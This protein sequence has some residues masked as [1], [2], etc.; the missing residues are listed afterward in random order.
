MALVWCAGLGLIM[1]AVPAQ[2]PVQLLCLA[3]CLWL[4][5]GVFSVL[6]WLRQ[7]CGTLRWDGETWYW[8]STGEVSLS[9][10]EVAA[11]F[12]QLLLLR[13]S[14][15]ELPAIWLWMSAG[16]SQTEWHAIRCALVHTQMLGLPPEA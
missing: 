15:A 5:A 9:S 8:S 13:V 16:V 1:L 11:D 14:G 6:Q 2:T 4:A 7:P 3:A 10:L 12:Q